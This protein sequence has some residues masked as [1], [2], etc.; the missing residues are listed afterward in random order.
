MSSERFERA[1]AAALIAAAGALQFSIAAGQ[2]LTAAAAV[3][4]LGVLVTGH[5]RFRAPRMFW[6]LAVYAAL[7]LV[8]AIF[9][10]DPRVSLVDCKQLVLFM[11]VPI[12]Y[13][14]LDESR[15]QLLAS[16]AMAVGAVSALYGIIQ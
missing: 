5:E 9:S 8:S 16:A 4:W 3:C 15:A 7:T 12:A 1:G 11:L 6:P 10:S 13:R 2:I 14:L